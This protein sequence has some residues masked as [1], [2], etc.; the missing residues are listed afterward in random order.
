MLEPDRSQMT[1][2]CMCIACWITKDTDTH[3]E[4]VTLI[5]FPLQHLLHE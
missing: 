5:A 4:Y 1:I 2:W 3:S